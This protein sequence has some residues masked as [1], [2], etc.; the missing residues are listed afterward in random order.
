[1]MCMMTRLVPSYCPLCTL[2]PKSSS[3]CPSSL[4]SLIPHPIPPPPKTPT[5]TPPGDSGIIRTLESPLYVVKAAAGQVT[6]LDRDGRVRVLAVEPAEY[7]FK[8]ALAQV[9]WFFVFGGGGGIGG[10]W[11][12]E[13]QVRRGWIRPSTVQECCH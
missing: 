2:L 6:A 3:P 1:M 5:P 4:Q 8:L 9:G 12:C 11:V 13:G 7:G 10:C